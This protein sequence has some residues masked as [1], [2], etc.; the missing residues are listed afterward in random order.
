MA[1]AFILEDRG[2]HECS[3][4]RSIYFFLDGQLKLMQ[5]FH[6][7][8][9]PREKAFSRTGHRHKEQISPVNLIDPLCGNGTAALH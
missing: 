4:R 7:D 5:N 3:I 1:T 8:P 6:R 2:L 9:T